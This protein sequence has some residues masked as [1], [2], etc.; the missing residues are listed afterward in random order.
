[1]RRKFLT[2]F[3]TETAAA[4]HSDVHQ[5]RV[6]ASFCFLKQPL[7]I[8]SASVHVSGFKM[9]PLGNI[10]RFWFSEFVRLKSIKVK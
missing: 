6:P 7:F 1:M 10:I 8:T 4:F 9:L 2:A 5:E 3:P